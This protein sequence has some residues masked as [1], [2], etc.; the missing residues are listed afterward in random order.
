M[1]RHAVAGLNH[2]SART[3]TET[4]TEAEAE[5]DNRDWRPATDHSRY[6]SRHDFPS[7]RRANPRTAAWML[8]GALISNC[9]SPAI[10]DDLKAPFA[11]FRRAHGMA[12]CQWKLGNPAAALEHARNACDRAGDGG[13]IR[14]RCMAL[15]L[16]AHFVPAEQ[17]IPLRARASR[18]ARQIEIEVVLADRNNQPPQ[19]SA[20]EI[21]PL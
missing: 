4:E 18:L 7:A 1:H 13:F 8:V 12:Y 9:S 20:P 14:F 17:A 6:T 3:E 21:R 5:T 16:I 10:A 2:C 19:R 15:D 11:Q